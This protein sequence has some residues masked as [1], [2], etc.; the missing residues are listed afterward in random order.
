MD[1]QDDGLP[2]AGKEAAPAPGGSQR[3]SRLELP[4]L[5]RPHPPAGERTVG[6]DGDRR[7]KVR[8][9]ELAQ[10]R[11]QLGEESGE[12]EAHVEQKS[13]GGASSPALTF[14]AVAPA[15]RGVASHPG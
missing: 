7:A 1:V 6:G 5:P 13:I 8:P 9:R 3:R 4:R 14:R 12:S 2:G 10:Q 11:E 15:E